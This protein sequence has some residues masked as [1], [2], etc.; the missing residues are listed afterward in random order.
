MEQEHV[1]VV[2]GVHEQKAGSIQ[3]RLSSKLFWRL[4][5]FLSEMKTET[6]IANIRLMSREYVNALLSLPEK[7]IFLGGLFKWP[8]FRQRA[9]VIVR[10]ITRRQSTYSLGKRL[11]LAVRSIV[12]F[13]AR[14]LHLIFWLGLAI[15]IT[16]ALVAISYLS[17]KIFDPA[18][19]LSGF[20]TIIVSIWFLSGLIMASLGIIGIYVAYIYSEVKSRPRT[21]V[22]RVHESSLGPTGSFK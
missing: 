13:S 7:N 10:K 6:D 19:V 15:A 14:P 5:N 11:A 21:V 20:T 8:G 2:F 18:I 16:S 9:V 17:A 1:D 4:F 22:R 3:R 12:A